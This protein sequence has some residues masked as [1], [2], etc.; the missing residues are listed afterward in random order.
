MD[1]G[2]DPDLEELTA[3]AERVFAD[4]ASAERVAEIELSHDRVDDALWHRL[5]GTGLLGLAIDERFGGSGRGVLELAVLLQHQGRHVAP[6]PLWPTLVLGAMPIARSGT[7]A[8]QERWLASVADGTCLL[9]GAFEGVDP[10]RTVGPVSASADPAG[11]LRLNGRLASVPAAHVATRIVVPVVVPAGGW[12]LVLLDPGTAGVRRER[13]VTTDR[14]IHE[15]LDLHDVYA[16]SAETTSVSAEELGYLLDV[17]RTML[18]AVQVGVIERALAMTTAHVSSRRQ[19]GHV[20][21]SFQAV[22]MRAADAYID[23]EAMRLTMVQAAWLLAN[24]RPAEAEAA[25]ANWWAAEAGHRCIHTAL[26]LHGGVG[27]DLEYPLHRY[28]LWSRQ[29]GLMLGGAARSLD[30]LAGLVPQLR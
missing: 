4:H 16:P 28:F 22:T 12:N 14:Q 23:L 27:N 30:R 15:H 24:D 8:Q 17:A 7:A 3:L 13:A 20:L 10:A 6:V 5:A 25:A 2:L 1:F 26:H 21:A 29:L 18:C 11:G 9:T 19:F